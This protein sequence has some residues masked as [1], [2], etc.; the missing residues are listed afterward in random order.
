MLANL[1]IFLGFQMLLPVMPVYAS[2]LG[3]GDSWAGVVVGIFTITALVMRPISGYLLDNIGRRIVF[4]TGLVLFILCTLSYNFT[5]TIAGLLAMRLIH[6]LG[7]GAAGTASSTIATDTVPKSRLGEA[8]GYFGLTSTM[9]IAIGPALGLGLMD[10]SGFDMVFS[11][12]AALVLVTVFISFLISYQK[13]GRPA[14]SDVR[15]KSGLIEKAAVPSAI[16][17]FFCNLSYGGIVSFITLYA[18]QRGV[19]NIGLFFTVFAIAIFAVRLFVG[20]I[21]DRKGYSYVIYPGILCLLIAM[22]VLAFAYNLGTFL[23]AGAIYGLGFG[24]L[25]PTLQAMSVRNVTPQRRGAA[26]GT[27]FVGFDLGLGTGAML[28][29]IIAQA[30]GYQAIY[31]WSILPIGIS[32]VLYALWQRKNKQTSEP[33]RSNDSGGNDTENSDIKKNDI[34]NSDTGD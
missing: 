26:T 17:M 30:M 8:M 24:S 5:I 18:I 22:L 33:V 2:A 3:G 12:S 21:A 14:K 7:W 11:V 29:G 4:V 23:L 25:M 16:I 1:F 28:W 10:I 15:E 20:R 34:K 19:E 13:V 27:F 6:G 32:F 9:A 31:L